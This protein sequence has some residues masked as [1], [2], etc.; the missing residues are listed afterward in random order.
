MSLRLTDFGDMVVGVA[1]AL[2]VFLILG[3]THHWGYRKGL[4]EARAI[5]C[6]SPQGIYENPALC[7]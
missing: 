2:T 4:E 5:V 3:L 1:V 6:D 7:E